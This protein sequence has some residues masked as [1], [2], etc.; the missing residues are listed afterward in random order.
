VTSVEILIVIAT[1]VVGAGLTAWLVVLGMR[2]IM[3]VKHKSKHGFD[4]T[5][6]RIKKVVEETDGWAFPAPEWHFSDVMVKHE[7]PFKG[8][9]GLILF[10]ICKADHVHNIVNTKPKMASIMPCGWAL[11]ERNGETYIGTMNIPMMALPFKGIIK[12]TFGAVGREEGEM[13][14]KIFN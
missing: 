4:E 11:Y 3:V 13:L 9:D 7:K 1:F 12:E 8:V 5:V 14:H 10:F 6:K 2:H